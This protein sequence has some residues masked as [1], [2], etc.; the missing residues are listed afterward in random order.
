MTYHFG[1]ADDLP[2]ALHHGNGVH[3]GVGAVA[4]FADYLVFGV[5]ERC[6]LLQLE[7]LFL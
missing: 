3:G 2:F 7:G 6:A 5:H 4:Q 1:S